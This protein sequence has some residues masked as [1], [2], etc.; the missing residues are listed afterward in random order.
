MAAR[1]L[2]RW[3]M[4]G[5]IGTIG[6]TDGAMVRPPRRQDVHIY[7]PRAKVADQVTRADPAGGLPEARMDQNVEPEEAGFRDR[8]IRLTGRDQEGKN[9]SATI[10]SPHGNG[11]EQEEPDKIT[12]DANACN[13]GCGEHPAGQEFTERMAKAIAPSDRAHDRN[14]EGL[15]GLAELMRVHYARRS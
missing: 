13:G 8:G 1:N 4:T 2:G 11:Y 12:A 14:P 9:W 6:T 3:R 7:L 15:R 5:P 10:Y